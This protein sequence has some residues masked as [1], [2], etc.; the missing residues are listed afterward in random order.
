MGNV[1][2]LLSSGGNHAYLRRFFDANNGDL[3]DSALA[4]LSF[5]DLVRLERVSKAMQYAIRRYHRRHY[6][7]N[8]RLSKFF[9]DTYAFRVMQARTCT[10]ISGSF[11]L[12][13]L[14]NTVYPNSDLDLYAHA[15]TA[16]DAAQWLTRQGYRWAPGWDDEGYSLE[17]SLPQPIQLSEEGIPEHGSDE[18]DCEFVDTE[19]TLKRYGVLGLKTILYFEKTNKAIN[20]RVRRQPQSRRKVQLLFAKITPLESIL[21]FH[22]SMWAF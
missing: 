16:A 10:V 2:S 20:V 11:A 13:H 4:V 12:Q 17:E 7:L 3:C 5:H 14:M 21:N 22:T 8:E 19:E 6:L 9:P 1:A 15:H 18:S